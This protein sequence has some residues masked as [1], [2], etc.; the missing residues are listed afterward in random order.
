MDVIE[1]ARSKQCELHSASFQSG[2]P[3][4]GTDPP[5]TWV[6]PLVQ[7]KPF[8]IHID[9]LVTETLLTEA[10]RGDRLHLTTGYFNLT[11][12][13]MDLVLGTRAD[14]NILLASPEVNGFYGARGIAGA[15]PSAYVHIEHQF[16]NELCR[17]RQHHR[18]Q[19]REYFRDQ[20]TFHA[21][22][23]NI[24]PSTLASH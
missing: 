1:T 3:A 6:Y 13:Y 24:R 2:Q 11:Q 19:L 17:K 12:G 22:G 7:M 4:P 23:K 16:Y 15:I 21:K 10:E 18:V 20:W 14:Y 9:E 8:G 5:D